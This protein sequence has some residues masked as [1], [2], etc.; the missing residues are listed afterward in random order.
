MMGNLTVDFAN[1]NLYTLSAQGLNEIMQIRWQ[2]QMNP[3]IG[4]LLK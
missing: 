2:N 1:H 3:E 4:Q